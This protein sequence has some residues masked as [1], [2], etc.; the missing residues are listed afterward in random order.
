M[1]DTSMLESIQ[2]T[3][4]EHAVDRHARMTAC[5]ENIDMLRKVILDE[6][7]PHVI[8]LGGGSGFL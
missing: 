1:H 3:L 7:S 2:K 6:V 4:S 5:Y 8:E